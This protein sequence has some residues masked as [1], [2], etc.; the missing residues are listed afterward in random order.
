MKKPTYAEL[1]RVVRDL[2]A[3]S[4]TFLRAALR[5]IEK[6]DDR[7]MASAV[8]V[9]LQALGGREIARPFAICDGL[10]PATIAA[11]RADIERTM[12]LRGFSK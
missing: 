10:S 4:A 3:Q 12:H 2:E 8:V 1:Q 6:A 7:L 9:T 11:I 5:D